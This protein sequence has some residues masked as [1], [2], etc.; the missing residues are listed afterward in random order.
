MQA[1]CVALFLAFMAYAPDSPIRNGL[2]APVVM[3]R[4]EAKYTQSARDAK[5]EGEVDLSVLVDETGVPTEVAVSKS[6]EPTLDASAVAAVKK[7]RFKPG[8][9]AGLPVEARVTV[10][11]SFRLGMLKN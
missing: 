4:E 8:T 6:L 10:R 11:I 1:I 7:W 9:R 5:V 3:Y 2:I